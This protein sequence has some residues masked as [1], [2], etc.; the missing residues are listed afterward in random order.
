MRP[1]RRR[2]GRLC[3]AP[4]GPAGPRRIGAGATD[5]DV[6]AGAEAAA[7][8]EETLGDS[9]GGADEA[10]TGAQGLRALVVTPTARAQPVPSPTALAELAGETGLAVR[11]D[12][13]GLAARLAPTCSSRRLSG[14]WRSAGHRR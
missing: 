5:D 3:P 2:D 12:G 9:G 13:T 10:A 1:W 7:G 8:T 4:P 11:A 6:E 14:P